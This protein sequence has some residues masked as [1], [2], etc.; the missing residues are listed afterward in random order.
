MIPPF[1]IWTNKVHCVG[2][3]GTDSRPAT[4]SRSPSSY[5]NNELGAIL[6]STWI[7]TT[8]ESQHDTPLPW[9]TRIV[10]G[11]SSH[12]AWPVVE[13]AL[14]HRIIPYCLPPHSIHLMQPLD[15]A[16]FGLLGR[17]YRTALQDFIYEHPGQ[18]FGKQ[19][20]W[21]YLCTAC[22]QAITHSNIL[23]EFEAS[24]IGYFVRTRWWIAI[25]A[26][27]LPRRPL[28]I[29]QLHSRLTGF[30]KQPGALLWPLIPVKSSVNPLDIWSAV[31]D[32]RTKL[33]RDEGVGNT[34]AHVIYWQGIWKETMVTISQG[35]L[36]GSAVTFGE[37]I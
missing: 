36:K 3:N 26:I 14:D 16:C 35:F 33:L 11:H 37:R 1:I 17:A 23:S 10:D 34:L 32:D 8:P 20:F 4:F 19:K 2:F 21:E 5:M 27:Q 6:W 22:E 18:S 28:L 24:G 29:H 15:V 7:H 13:C 31:P 25:K 12:I 30:E 9:R